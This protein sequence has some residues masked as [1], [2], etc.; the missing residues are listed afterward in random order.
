MPELPERF[1]LAPHWICEILSAKTRGYD[2][3]VKRPF[4]A[5]I[6]VEWLGMWT[7]TRGPSR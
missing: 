4:Y 1:T 5:E 6:G 3:R 7:S 2:L